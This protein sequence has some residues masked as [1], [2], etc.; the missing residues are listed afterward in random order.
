MGWGE[1]GKP[2]P[3][4]Q[5]G[6]LQRYWRQPALPALP[7]KRNAA[8]GF[9]STP[10]R[11]LW[12][13]GIFEHR[14]TRIPSSGK[15]WRVATTRNNKTEAACLTCRSEPCTSTRYSHFV[16]RTL[17]NRIEKKKKGFLIRIEQQAP[18]RGQA[19]LGSSTTVEGAGLGGFVASSSLTTHLALAGET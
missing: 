8:S 6:H 13:L 16:G 9:L 2:A 18:Q 4:C 17:F 3:H 1:G 7:S 12:S 10:A 5:A 15:F 19:P 11:T 14:D